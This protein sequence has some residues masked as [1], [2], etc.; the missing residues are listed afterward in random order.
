MTGVPARTERTGCGQLKTGA[1]TRQA[2]SE[3]CVVICP[4]ETEHLPQAYAIS[5]EGNGTGGFEKGSSIDFSLL[6]SLTESTGLIYC[7]SLGGNQS[8]K[9]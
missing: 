7:T 3:E 2:P 4:G 6:K 5:S 8:P 9:V 1:R